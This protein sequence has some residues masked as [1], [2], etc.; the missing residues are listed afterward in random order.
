[1]SSTTIDSLGIH[2]VR[3]DQRLADFVAAFKAIYG[4]DINVDP[5][6]IDGQFLGI[7]SEM[8][9]DA[10]SLLEQIYLARSPASAVGADLSR[11]VQ[12]IGIAR[13]VAS[14]STASVVHSGVIGTVIPDGSLIDTTDTPPAHFQTVGV[15]TIDASGTAPGVVRATTTGPVFAAAGTITAIKTVISGWASVTNAASVNLGSDQE[16]DAA[17]RVRRAASVAI[18]SKSIIDGIYAALANIQGVSEAVVFENR[19][20]SPISRPGSPDLQANSLQCVVRGGLDSDIAAAIWAKAS[21]GVTL[22]GAIAATVTDS[23]GFAQVIRFD[24]PVD[25]AIYANVFLGGPAGLAASAAFVLAVKQALVDY[26]SGL[27][28]IGATVVRA[29]CFIPVVGVVD[30]SGFS[31]LFLN[32]GLTSGNGIVDIPIPFTS[33]ASWDVS[34]VNVFYNIG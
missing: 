15:A 1:M 19:T 17:L 23:Q 31:L 16:T 26:M 30:G 34:R 14:Y 29:R 10:D 20:G 12:L 8:A 6:T 25:I 9:A 2:R 21:A 7:V 5:D 33:R 4:D 28:R 22:V 3:L 24:R 32:I 18:S 13:N 11:I 27:A